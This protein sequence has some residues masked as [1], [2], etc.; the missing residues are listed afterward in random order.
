KYFGGLSDGSIPL[1][2]LFSGT[3]FYA[4]GGVAM[5]VAPISWEKEARFSL[6]VGI[7][8]E[9]MNAYYPN[10][11]WLCLR[12]DVFERLYEYKRQKAFPTWDQALETILPN[13]CPP[14]KLLRTP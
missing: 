2:F 5:Q 13:P 3:I 4:G 8:Q 1:C 14:L 12:R 11:A 10:S 6:P 9:M 7:W